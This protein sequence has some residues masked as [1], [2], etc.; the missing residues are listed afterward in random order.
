MFTQ[1]LVKGAVAALL[2][3]A[4]V[5][6]PTVAASPAQTPPPCGPAVVVT[7]KTTVDLQLDYKDL[8]LPLVFQTMPPDSITGGNPGSWTV[9]SCPGSKG[10]NDAKIGYGSHDGG[11]KVEVETEFGDYP[12]RTSCS[13][14]GKLK[15]SVDTGEGLAPTVNVSS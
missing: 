15:C 7:V 12:S 11:S 10:P 8:D 13:V 5:G 3:G 1:V 4:V 2:V 9:S 6:A 14:T